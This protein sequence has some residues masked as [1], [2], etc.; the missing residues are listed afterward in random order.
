MRFLE[1]LWAKNFSLC[2][3]LP[4]KKLSGHLLHADLGRESHSIVETDKQ[5]RYRAPQIK[6]KTGLLR[7]SATSNGLHL[8]TET[9]TRYT[10]FHKCI[11]IL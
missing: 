3:I 6:K 4:Q 2:H 11:N 7:I 8:Q 5:L 10:E 1:Y 9:L